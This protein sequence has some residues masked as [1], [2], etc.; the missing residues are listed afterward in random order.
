[1][2]YKASFNNT[3]WLILM[4]MGKI[5]FPFVLFPYLAHRLN[6]E[7]YGNY[8][9]IRSIMS[10]VTIIIDY[11]FVYSGT[12]IIVDNKESCIKDSKAVSEIMISKIILALIS[13]IFVIITF[14]ISELSRNMITFGLALF[15]ATAI[16]SLLPDFFFR[17]R[18]RMDIIARR[19]LIIKGIAMIITIFLV[20]ADSDVYKI[21]IVEIVSSVMA[22]WITY[23]IMKRMEIQ[24]KVV[25]S[26]SAQIKVFK[27][28]AHYFISS[29]A[30]MLYGSFNTI[31]I[32]IFLSSEETAYWG[33]GYNVLYA[34][35]SMYVPITN[36]IYPQM[37]KTKD[38][39]LLRRV[40]LLLFPM[41]IAGT[42]IIFFISD[43]LMGFLG[44]SAY[45]YKG[46][47][48]QLLCPVIIF[49]FPSI[50][51]GF[52]GLG[53][54]GRNHELSISVLISATFH[55]GALFILLAIDKLSVVSVCVLRSIT[56]LV[57]LYI[58]C[59]YLKKFK[60]EFQ[61]I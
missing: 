58:K 34:I 12:N 37:V 5:L 25:F 42:I 19:F 49:G 24:C 9:Y 48:I 52:S 8:T 1:M 20:K 28:G 39:R 60:N 10:F 4:N 55:V 45:Q 36:G 23:I 50:L 61:F 21:A 30:P 27:E 16:Q 35:L 15:F 41:V 18:E 14:F 43:F 33:I 53:A 54:I 2:K 3:I 13:F 17:G 47:I 51:L 26:A 31:I 38:L 46:Y 7:I 32:G 11:G 44:G 22:V 56:E 40:F 6:T 57:C 29:V 59:L